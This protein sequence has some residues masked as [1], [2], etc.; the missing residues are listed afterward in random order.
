[1]LLMPNP[2]SRPCL[3]DHNRRDK[4]LLDQE[5]GEQSGTSVHRAE[6]SAIQDARIRGH[7]LLYD[8]GGKLELNL[9]F[10]HPKFADSECDEVL[11]SAAYYKPHNGLWKS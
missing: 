10:L 11:F 8:K 4:I 6:I 3:A 9:E 7:E 5:V 2:L 1:M